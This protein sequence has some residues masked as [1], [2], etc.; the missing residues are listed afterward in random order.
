MSIKKRS[1]FVIR[2][3]PL[4]V[5]V[6]V[7]GSL[8]FIVHHLLTRWQTNTT[9]DVGKETMT[10]LFPRKRKSLSWLKKIY[11]LVGFFFHS[12]NLAELI[13]FNCVQFRKTTSPLLFCRNGKILR[14][15]DNLRWCPSAGPVVLSSPAQ[16]V[17]PVLV[18]RGTLSITTSEIYFEVD[19]DDPVFKRADAK[20]R[21]RAKAGTV[22]RFKL[23][24]H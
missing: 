4:T 21:L 24:H 12:L 7:T 17:A 22:F 8:H 11:I 3:Q 18:A 19:E 1:V 20:V 15:S 10:I 14:V 5:I 23:Y 2:P 9:A 13:P 16:L 6:R